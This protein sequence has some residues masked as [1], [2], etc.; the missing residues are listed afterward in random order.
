[1]LKDHKGHKV[2]LVLQDFRVRQVLKEIS[3]LLQQC[4][5]QEDLKVH[6]EHRVPLE[7]LKVQQ[8]L[9]EYRELKV[10]RGPLLESKELRDLK[11]QH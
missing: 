9:K 11:V 5:E 10:L 1:V 6:K 2:L 3:E 8:V 4:R 7:M